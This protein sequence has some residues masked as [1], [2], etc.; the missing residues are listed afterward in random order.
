MP[1]IAE[2]C[3][4]P[5][6]Y[7]LVSYTSLGYFYPNAVVPWV[8]MFSDMTGHFITLANSSEE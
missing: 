5:V 7:L 3:H 2:V 6:L 1:V 4:Q 8:T